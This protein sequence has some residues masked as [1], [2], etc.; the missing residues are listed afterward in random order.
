MIVEIPIYAYP[1]ILLLFVLQNTH[2]CQPFFSFSMDISSQKSKRR[3]IMIY[4]L[5]QFCTVLKGSDFEG[6]VSGVL[7]LWE[8][9]LCILR[10]ICWMSSLDTSLLWLPK[11]KLSRYNDDTCDISMLHPTLPSSI[12]AQLEMLKE[13]TWRFLN[14]LFT[15]ES[16][17]SSVKDKSPVTTVN[18]RIL[19]IPTSKDAHQDIV[20]VSNMNQ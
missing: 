11:Y 3:G 13:S 16:V 9:P 14:Q 15:S 20:R 18:D 10:W 1:Y 12:Q 19:R 2:L 4:S 17:W 6:L 8:A 5:L 7:C